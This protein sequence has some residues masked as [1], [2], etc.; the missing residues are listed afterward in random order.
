MAARIWRLFWLTV[1]VAHAMSALGWWWL[2]PGGFGWSHPRFW[3]NRVAPWG[4][5]GLAIATLAAL[6]QENADGLSLLLPSWPAA[7][8]AA[9][10][11]ARLVF[12]VTLRWVWVIPMASA[13]AMGVAAVLPARHSRRRARAGGVFLALGSACFS[14]TLIGLLRAPKPATHPLEVRLA[15]LDAG[16]PAVGRRAPGSIRLDSGVMVQTADAS[17]TVRLPAVTVMVEPLLSFLT[18]S[19]DGFPTIPIGRGDESR[20][21]PHLRTWRRDGAKQCTLI[22]DFAK[23]GPALLDVTML[24]E[25]A[26]ADIVA[27]ARLERPVYSHLNSFCDFE[28]RGHHRLA[29]Q[30]SPC[31][32]VP[33]EAEP[34]DYPVGRPVR[35]AF[36][37]ADRTFRVVEA[38]SGEKGPFHTLARGRLSSEQALSITLLDQDR[39]VGRIELQ[40][41]A[42]QADTGLSPTAGWGVPVNAIEFSRSGDSPASPASIFVTLAGT[43]VGRGWDCVGHAPGTYRNRIRVGP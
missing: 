23:Q 35:F 8:A 37:E 6:K 12:P 29:L 41:W 17:V 3:C 21:R 5:F 39:R 10:G 11:V 9:A 22:Y 42:R 15:D 32:S 26:A 33:I 25:P 34:F 16:L 4:V 30:F 38:S 1:L 20:P 7:W 43:S 36:V 24:A 18:E 40:D 19:P 14:G 2:Q 13:A 31:E 27:A 28:V